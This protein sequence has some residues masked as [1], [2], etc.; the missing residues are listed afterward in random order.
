MPLR[1]RI[2]ASW[3]HIQGHLFPWLLTE[4]GPLTD[5]HKRLVTVLEMVRVEGVVSMRDGGPGRPLDDRHALAR[6]FIAKSVL[7]LAT[8]A[9]LIERLHV[10]PTLRRLIGWERAAHVPSEATFSRAF[11]EFADGH[12]PERA[13]EALIER[14]LEDHL[15]GHIARDATA[16]EVR[17]KPDRREK[18]QAE[19]PKRKRGRPRKGELVP[20]KEPRRLERQTGQTLSEMLADLPTACDVGTKRNAKGYKTS[21]TGYKLHIDTADGDIPITCLL[22]SASVHDS[23]VAIPLAT[24]T[25]RRVTNLYDLMDSAYDAPEIRENSRSL[26]H[27]AI[28]EVNP[29]RGGK[30][31]A[32]AEARAKRSAGYQPAEDVR[33]NQRSSAERVNS[34]LKDNFGGTSVR[35]RGAAKVFCH[36]M[37]GIVV[38]TCDQLMRLII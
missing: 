10:D 9:A 27:V 11:A 34:N 2:S 8:T 19:A 21:W 37:F 6:A 30:A 35:V 15:I 18:P 13:H 23:Q 32:E 25:A 38:L 5:N 31:N 36:L 12:V 16:I 26:G 28:I 33:Y 20:Q 14:T 17:E 29:R 24:I 1:E 22:T 4:V 3:C 7:N